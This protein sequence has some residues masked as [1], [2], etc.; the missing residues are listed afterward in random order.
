MKSPGAATTSAIPAP[1]PI[2]AFQGSAR[3]RR[4]NM[5]NLRIPC[6]Q[7]GVP[8]PM[9]TSLV[10]AL[11]AIL[12]SPI[13]LADDHADQLKLI[14]RVTKQLRSRDA[15]ERIEAAEILGKVSIPEAIPP[16]A[17]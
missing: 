17:S 10:L 15:S 4:V 6:H 3:V 8:K 16:L 14:E 13:A 5:I 1:H 7:K 11:C 2:C 9:R 12:V